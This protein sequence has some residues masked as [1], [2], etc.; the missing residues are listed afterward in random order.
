MKSVFFVMFL[1]TGAK[2]W[3]FNE[4]LVYVVIDR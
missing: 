4:I 2:F 1:S 3:A